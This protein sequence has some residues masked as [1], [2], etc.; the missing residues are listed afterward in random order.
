[1]RRGKPVLKKVVADQ[2]RA[3]AS[4]NDSLC[5]GPW[6]AETAAVAGLSHDSLDRVALRLL[7]RY[8]G[9]D[10]GQVS[11]DDIRVSGNKRKWGASWRQ[12]PTCP[13]FA[14]A[15]TIRRLVKHA[16]LHHRLPVRQVVQGRISQ[17]L[18]PRRSDGNRLR[19][20]R[21]AREDVVA[22]QDQWVS[23]ATAAVPNARVV[24]GL[25]SAGGG[26]K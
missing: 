2:W 21:L 8:A 15:G 22:V 17:A 26:R 19:D 5:G 7:L 11:E 10:Q 16:Y 12:T 3:A 24:G 9:R 1:M 18:H 4:F 20:D 14:G 6:L 25:R 23:K 13:L